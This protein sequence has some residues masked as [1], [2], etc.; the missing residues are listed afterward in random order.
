MKTSL[1]AIAIAALLTGA[2]AHAQALEDDI[3]SELPS[4]P[5]EQEASPQQKADAFQ[6]ALDEAAGISNRPQPAPK[7]E[8]VVAAPQPVIEKEN[9]ELLTQKTQMLH[10]DNEVGEA[11]TEAY[12]Q[13]INQELVNLKRLKGEVASLERQVATTN[14]SIDRAKKKAALAEKRVELEKHRKAELA[15]RMK[16]SGAQRQR[17][18]QALARLKNASADLQK[19]IAAAAQQNRADEKALAEMLRE[20]SALERRLKLATNR[21]SAE[22]KKQKNLR[23]RRTKLTKSNKDLKAKIGK[24][25]RKAGGRQS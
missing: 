7:K 12:E 3:S 1:L 10:I 9:N 15:A 21:L 2:N 22:M 16:Q 18:E 17:A 6:K 25:E 8:K 20:N 11:E 14:S 23:D 24:A 13:Y 5:N 4:S 19:K